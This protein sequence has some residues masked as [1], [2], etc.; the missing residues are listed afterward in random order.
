MKS[1]KTLKTVNQTTSTIMPISRAQTSSTNTKKRQ[2]FLDQDYALMNY[3]FNGGLDY[4]VLFNKTEDEK[5]GSFSSL[6]YQSQP[7]LH[8]SKF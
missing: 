5:Y 8:Y 6:N 1:R 4:D 7:T 3:N 2:Y